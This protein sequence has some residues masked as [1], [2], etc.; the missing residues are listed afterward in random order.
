MDKLREWK[1]V[2]SLMGDLLKDIQYG[3]VEV[4]KGSAV[5][6]WAERTLKEILQF[7]MDEDI[8]QSYDLEAL[9]ETLY[10]LTAD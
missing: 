7:L 9:E 3:T 10:L 1:T 5:Y 6:Y 4:Q 8:I 2:Y